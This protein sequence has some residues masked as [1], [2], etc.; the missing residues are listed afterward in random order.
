MT[1]AD[2]HNRAAPDATQRCTGTVHG[3]RFVDI[4]ATAVGR[5]LAGGDMAQLLGKDLLMRVNA[6][7]LLGVIGGGL[8][9]CAVAAV[10]YDIGLLLDLW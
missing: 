5:R 2:C 8:V 9:L 3:A 10:V 7:L 1:Q 6:A 4:I